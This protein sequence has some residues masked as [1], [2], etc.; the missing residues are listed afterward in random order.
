M[1][2]LGI[3]ALSQGRGSSWWPNRRGRPAVAGFVRCGDSRIVRGECRSTA[4]TPYF[5][6]RAILRQALDLE[7]LNPKETI[8]KLAVRVQEAAPELLPW[9]SLIGL[10]LNV[11][12]EPSPE[13]V[14]LDEQFR[15]ARTIAAV[16]HLLEA[17]VTLRTLIVVE[18]THWM[19]DASR[20][21]LAGLLF[22]LERHP[23]ML[24][25]T[26]RPGEAGFVAP[27]S[28]MVDSIELQPL[29]HE[30]A[31]DLNARNQQITPFGPIMS[32]DSR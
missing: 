14:Q 2:G 26:R 16:G 13:V 24:V 6:F 12:I 20:E 7:G 15:P 11:E 32:P 8:E 22:G 5:P 28:G 3:W 23:W 29:T 31:E 21:L 30:H 19:D 1:K 9:L 18:D 27:A 10:V 4:A 25:L 17:V